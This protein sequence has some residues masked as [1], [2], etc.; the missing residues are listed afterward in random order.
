MK[1]VTREKARE[2]AGREGAIPYDVPG[3]R[4]GCSRTSRG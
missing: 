4:R 3:V 2:V 1:W